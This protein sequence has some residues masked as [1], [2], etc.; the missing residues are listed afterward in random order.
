MRWQLTPVRRIAQIS[1]TGDPVLSA[2]DIQRLADRYG[3]LP[4]AH[5]A[6]DM[7]TSLHA[8]DADRRFPVDDRARSFPEEEPAPERVELVLAI[9]AGARLTIGW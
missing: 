4:S 5:G 9:E 3:A 1:V 2:S 6:A 8:Y 7:V